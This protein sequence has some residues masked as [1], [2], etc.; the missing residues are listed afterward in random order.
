MRTPD[1]IA[2]PLDW[3]QGSDESRFIVS[4]AN[5]A[6]FEHFRR[7]SSWPVKATVL[8]GP[9]RSGRSLLARNF[10]ARVNGRLFDSAETHDEEALFHAWNQAQETGRPMVMVADSPP[11][12]WRTALPD[13]RTRLAVTPVIRIEQPDDAL[14]A[15]LIRRLFADRGLHLPDEALRYVVSRVTRD[16]WTAERVVDAIDR[17]AIASQARLTLPTVRRALIAGGLIDGGSEE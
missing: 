12:K 4:T 3:P 6:A 10:V 17:F 9:R 5:E 8:I 1:Q 14:F 13:L 2:L 16:Y 7:W 15:S 11:T